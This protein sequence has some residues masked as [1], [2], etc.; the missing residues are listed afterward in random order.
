MPRCVLKNCFLLQKS[1]DG[2]GV[3]EKYC[4][5]RLPGELAQVLL[6]SFEL[7]KRGSEAMMGYQHLTIQ[8][9]FLI[10]LKQKGQKCF[11]GVPHFVA[12]PN[13]CY[14]LKILTAITL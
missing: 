7:C 6:C 14:L 11:G 2:A 3:D 1:L 9:G 10:F 13:S 4:V 12:W 5:L 8:M